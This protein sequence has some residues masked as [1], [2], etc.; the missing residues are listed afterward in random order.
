MTEALIFIFLC[1]INY[2]ILTNH[3]ELVHANSAA[4]KYIPARQYGMT[5]KRA[6]VNLADTGGRPMSGFRITKQSESADT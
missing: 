2:R 6:A 1:K 4:I 3:Y 5:Y